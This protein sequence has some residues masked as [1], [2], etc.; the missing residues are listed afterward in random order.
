M[1]AGI[2]I[3]K[4]TDT[5]LKHIELLAK[6]YNKPKPKT[7]YLTKHLDSC[8]AVRKEIRFINKCNINSFSTF[9]TSKVAIISITDYTNCTI[10]IKYTF[11]GTGYLFSEFRRY[12]K[13]H[14]EN[15]YL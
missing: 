15:I 11:K 5:F 13:K 6:E 9:Y 12:I 10:N 4:D 7:I 14:K 8:Q 2:Y 1:E 3:F